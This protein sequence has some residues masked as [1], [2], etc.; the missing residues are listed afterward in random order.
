[1]SNKTGA[2]IRITAEPLPGPVS[3]TS[4]LAAPRTM[5]YVTAA[6]SS[7][8]LFAVPRA[9]RAPSPG[10]EVRSLDPAGGHEAGLPVLSVEG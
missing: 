8:T 1:M 5:S 2:S 6:P 7:L 9:T 3:F 4:S 10:P